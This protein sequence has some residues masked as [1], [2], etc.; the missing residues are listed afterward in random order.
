MPAGLG[1]LDTCILDA[2]AGITLVVA[3][4]LPWRSADGS[5]LVTGIDLLPGRV[6]FAAGGALVLAAVIRWASRGKWGLRIARLL[7]DLAGVA[8]FGAIGAELATSA[9]AI[10]VIFDR[11]VHARLG[12]G[13]AV[14]AAG[15][16]L[17]FVAAGRAKR[18]LRALRFRLL[19]NH[20]PAHAGAAPSEGAAAR[21]APQ[22][23]A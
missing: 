20:G 11:G 15:A 21:N 10:G 16:V 2:V 14:T 1:V 9:G 4:L 17:A 22:S 7:S 23:T 18:Q 12:I 19:G 8:A 13:V 3:A 6:V 5:G